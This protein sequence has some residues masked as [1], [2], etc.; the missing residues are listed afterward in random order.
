MRILTLLLLF[1]LVFIY[2]CKPDPLGE[3]TLDYTMRIDSCVS[4]MPDFTY[5][6]TNSSGY[7]SVNY[8][9]ETYVSHISSRN[10]FTFKAS[11]GEMV[12]KFPLDKEGPTALEGVSQFDGVV[13][14]EEGKYL[15]ANQLENK[16]FLL[17]KS[18]VDTIVDLSI[19]KGYQLVSGFQNPPIVGGNYYLFPIQSAATKEINRRFGF[20]AVDKSFEGFKKV[21]MVSDEYDN[22]NYGAQPFLQWPSIVY[23][24]KS[25][26]YL[27]SF[28]IDHVLYEY[29]E[30]FNLTSSHSIESLIGDIVPYSKPIDENGYPTNFRE[31]RAYYW[32]VNHYIGLH[33]LSESDLYVRVGRKN[34]LESDDFVHSLIVFSSDFSNSAIFDIA[35]AFSVF[36]LF[37]NGDNLVI[38]NKER[39]LSEKN[40]RI[41]FDC[42]WF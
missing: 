20:V 38:L 5:N 36:N 6:Y 23:S 14:L 34:Y 37:P 28:P 33:Y 2:S 24:D 25:K 30:F 39:I 35:E 1:A 7:S 8:G 3:T 40:A 32:D 41:P 18:S 19:E 10:I 13:F 16:V 26:S 22:N 27:V 11:T 29:D 12:E 4:F 21:V 42:I 9:G 15:Y 31:D 17:T